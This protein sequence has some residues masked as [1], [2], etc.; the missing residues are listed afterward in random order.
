M[1]LYV[2]M[3]FFFDILFYNYENYIVLIGYLDVS[4][5]NGYYGCLYVIYYEYGYFKLEVCIFGFNW[6]EGEVFC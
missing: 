4:I 2:V 3:W 1:F 5:E 6:Y